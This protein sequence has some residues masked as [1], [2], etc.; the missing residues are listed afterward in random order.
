L[1]VYYDYTN[2]EEANFEE[3][4]HTLDFD[5][6]H[7]L[8]LIKSQELIWGAGYRLN[9]DDTSGVETGAP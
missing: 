6:Q 4:R 8:R 7:H 2:R 5:F 1:K 9:S 3:E